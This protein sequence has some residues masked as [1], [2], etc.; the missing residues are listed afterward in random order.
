MAVTLPALLLVYVIYH[1]GKNHKTHTLKLVPFFAAALLFSALAFYMV[2]SGK[3]DKETEL[4]YGFLEKATLIFSA[5]GFYFFK[6]F[7]PWNQQ[8]IY[9]F[10]SPADLFSP[11]EYYFLCSFNSSFNF[12]MYLFYLKK[13]E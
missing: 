9:L 3:V 1:Y 6:P 10:P 4:H 5:L 12:H 2:N 13:G 7:M 11:H 8:V